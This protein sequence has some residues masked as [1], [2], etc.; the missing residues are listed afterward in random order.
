MME[1]KEAAVKPAEGDKV[2]EASKPKSGGSGIG[3]IK[4]CIIKCR[5]SI[6]YLEYREFIIPVWYL[7]LTL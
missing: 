5:K 4:V 6:E 3:V 2:K 7:N 1:D